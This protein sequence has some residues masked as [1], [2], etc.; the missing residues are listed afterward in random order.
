MALD[1]AILRRPGR[2]DQIVPFPPPDLTLRQEY[3]RRLSQAPWNETTLAS[4]A[5]EAEGFSF[6]HLRESYILAAQL[7]FER[8]EADIRAGDLLEGIRL[9]KAEAQTAGSRIDGRGVGFGLAASRV[10]RRHEVSF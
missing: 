10:E 6:A 7:A 8:G 4:A 3:L 5:R 2:F 1:P 9:V